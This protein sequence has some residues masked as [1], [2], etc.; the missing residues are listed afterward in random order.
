MIYLDTSV[1]L[2]H[3]L[4]EDRGPAAALWREPLVASRLLEY[5]LWNRLN[6]RGLSGSHDEAARDLLG[7]VAIIE[8]ARP[9][10]ARALEPFPVPVRTLDALH[11]A[12]IEFLRAQSQKIELATYDERLTAAAKKMKI[13]LSTLV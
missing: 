6:A 12:S 11:L 2:A 8:L 9:V 5:E 10:L 4:A 3:L 7:R 1:A 13:R